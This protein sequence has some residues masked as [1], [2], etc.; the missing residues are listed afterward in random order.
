M[1]NENP[2]TK[3]WD[4]LKDYLKINVEYAKLTAA[5]KISVFLTAAA[6]A[7]GIFFLAIIFFFFLSL[8]LVN[9]LAISIGLAWSYAIM[10]AFYLLLIGVLIVF[11]KPLIMNP[12]AKFVSKLLLK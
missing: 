10:S 9:W 8:A 6:V 7:L 3:L 4:E 5:E 12:V 11:R 1:A 2:Y